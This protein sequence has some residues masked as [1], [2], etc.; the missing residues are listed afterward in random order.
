MVRSAFPFSLANLPW[1]KVIFWSKSR[2]LQ[3]FTNDLTL[4]VI[5]AILMAQ[6]Q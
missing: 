3:G 5:A 1:I 2:G 4:P 6:C